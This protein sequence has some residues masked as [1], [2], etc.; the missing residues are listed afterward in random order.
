MTGHT[1]PAGPDRTPVLRAIG[2][3]ARGYSKVFAGGRLAHRLSPA[4]PVRHAGFR[5][6]LVVAARRHVADGVVELTLTDGAGAP[7]PAWTPGAHLDVVTPEGRLRHYSLCGDPGERD[8]YRIAVRLLPGGGGGSRE[9]HGVRPGEGLTV[10]GP[11]NGFPFHDG[12]PG[13]LFVAAGIGITPILPMV[14]AA[15]AGS[16]PWALVHIGRSRA[17]LPYL[18]EAG[19][20]PGG[21]VVVHTT[22]HDGRPDVRDV[23]R[24][25]GRGDAVYVC[26]PSGL[27]D[28]VLRLAPEVLPDATSLH[29]ERFT[30]PVAG[31][32]AFTVAL[33]RSGHTLRVEPRESA[34]DRIRTVLPDVA[35]S[36][37]RGFC[38]T[39]RTGVLSG[40]V[41]HRDR[42]L[43]PGERDTEMAIC[44]SRAA[45]DT[46]LELDL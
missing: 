45:G 41:D 8:G 37:R 36:C 33:R 3:A 26:G 22:D 24:R 28:D 12:A 6:P 11:R 9:L 20:L 46:T 34:L 18:D 5:R 44:V 42:V 4:A 13:Y 7:L 16:A 31:G 17:T 30:T 40:A 15:A 35:Y 29:L 21:R 39:C 2:V 32:A 19:R 38:G 43:L 27:L 23:L 10:R 14:R 25:A 1:L